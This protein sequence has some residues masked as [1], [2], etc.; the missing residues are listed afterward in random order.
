MID[1]HRLIALRCSASAADDQQRMNVNET[2]NNQCPLNA[3]RP[4]F[5]HAPPVQYNDDN[6]HPPTSFIAICFHLHH[7]QHQPT[8]LTTYSTASKHPWQPLYPLPSALHQPPPSPLAPTRALPLPR[9]SAPPL[10]PPLARVPRPLQRSTT[11]PGPH[12]AA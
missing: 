6:Y 7:L 3:R 4:T 9:L 8:H 5:G 2:R 11:P 1:E 10:P 12:A